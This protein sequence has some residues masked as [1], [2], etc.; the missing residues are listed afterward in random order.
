MA[1]TRDG[2]LRAPVF[3]RFRDDK[4]PSEIVHPDAQLSDAVSQAVTP[5]PPRGRRRSTAIVYTSD[6]HPAMQVAESLPVVHGTA[7]DIYRDVLDQLSGNERALEL[8]IGSERLSLTHLDK[9][10][11]P[12]TE[13]GPAITKREYLRL[14]CSMA[15]HLLPHW[16]A[17][18]L[19]LFRAPEGVSGKAFF[20][21]NWHT[22]MPDFVETVALPNATGQK[23]FLLCNNLPS[24]L[25]FAQHS[26]LEFHSFS[27]R[28]ANAPDPVPGLG[29]GSSP[30]AVAALL[31]HP[32]YLILD[33]DYHPHSTREKIETFALDAFRRTAEVAL[34]LKENLEAVSLTPFV[35]LSGRNGLHIFVPVKRAVDFSVTR[36][37]ADTIARYLVSKKPQSVTMEVDIRK[38]AGK[39]YLD[40]S[41]NGPGKTLACAYSAR[42]IPWG[43]VSAPIAWSELSDIQPADLALCKM[44]QRL[45]SIGDPWAGIMSAK[46]DVNKAFGSKTTR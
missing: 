17:R 25:F 35:K 18:P 7:R 40:C 11:W 37:L 31:E 26:V 14:L 41:A 4:L 34:E 39:V 22:N 12:A 8:I 1:F 29:K 28:I 21:K 24:L 13:L 16:Q 9:V 27:S 19:T 5:V 36:T 2:H 15:P 44:P 32:D 20:Q 23:E 3:L 10:F 43:A 42:A 33:L 46:Q 6:S 38:R 30:A 45:A